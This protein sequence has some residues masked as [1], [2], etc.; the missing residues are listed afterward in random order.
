MIYLSLINEY[1]AVLNKYASTSLV[2][3]T[4]TVIDNLRK[5]GGLIV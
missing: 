1:E 4:T 5:R 2:K 3:L